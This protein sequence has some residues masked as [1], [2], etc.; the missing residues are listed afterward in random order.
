MF[1]SL[2]FIYLF[3][4]A[5]YFMLPLSCFTLFTCVGVNDDPSRGDSD[6]HDE[7]LIS[8]IEGFHGPGVC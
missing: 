6:D 8:F 2:L 5:F 4:Q 7:E 3:L 1:A